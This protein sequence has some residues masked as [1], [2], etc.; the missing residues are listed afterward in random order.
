MALRWLEK[1]GTKRSKWVIQF[2][3]EKKEDDFKTVFAELGPKQQEV[4]LD[5][6]ALFKR[7]PTVKQIQDIMEELKS[8]AGGVGWLLPVLQKLSDIAVKAGTGHS[9]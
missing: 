5:G 6:L 4:V 9:E 2:I 3:N 1:I 8:S 7:T